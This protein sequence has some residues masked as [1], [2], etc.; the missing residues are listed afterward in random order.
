MWKFTL[1]K[2]SDERLKMS[3]AK[4]RDKLF[5]VECGRFGGG[6]EIDWRV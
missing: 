6:K 1:L 5:L 4:F 2:G 3:S